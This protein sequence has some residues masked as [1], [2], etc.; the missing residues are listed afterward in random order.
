M[1]SKPTTP[2]NAA[3]TAM[4]P[5]PRK[6]PKHGKSILTSLPIELRYMIYSSMVKNRT[7]YIGKIK[8]FSHAKEEITVQHARNPKS[9]SGSGYPTPQFH[10]TRWYYDPITAVFIADGLR[11]DLGRAMGSRVLRETV[12]HV[13]LDTRWFPRKSG[14]WNVFMEGAIQELA[15]WTGLRRFDV[16]CEKG[17]MV[18]PWMEERVWLWDV[19]SWNIAGEDEKKEVARLKACGR[20][21]AEI[22]NRRAE[23]RRE[24]M[25]SRVKLR[26]QLK[27]LNVR[28]RAWK[29]DFVR[30]LSLG[31]NTPQSPYDGN[32]DWQSADEENARRHWEWKQAERKLRNENKAHMR[33]VI[34]EKSRDQVRLEKDCVKGQRLKG[35]WQVSS[36]R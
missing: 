20:L 10:K 14:G 23:V 26:L 6:K 36:A 28:F 5:P 19:Y 2:A 34:M 25:L 18:T 22:R 15:G 27:E 9:K 17:A 35:R 31:N 21:G 16:R 33:A 7:I 32:A 1:S 24:M 12:R 8:R 4:S 11:G 3:A 13:V 30:R 29:I